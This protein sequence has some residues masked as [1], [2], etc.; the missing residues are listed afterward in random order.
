MEPKRLPPSLR[1]KSR[2]VIF[3][4]ISEGKVVFE[5]VTKAIWNAVTEWLG[6]MGSS[7]ARLWIVKNLYSDSKQIGVIKCAHDRVEHIRVSLAL[8]KMTGETRA[9]IRV[10]GVTGTIK[11]AQLK[12][13]EAGK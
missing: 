10:I 9:I 6:E 2:Y 7:E 8:V 12:Y 11:A 13:L 5:D 1:A 3:E 4:V